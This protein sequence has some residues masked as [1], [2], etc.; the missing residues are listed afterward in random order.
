MLMLIFVLISSVAHTV[1]CREVISLKCFKFR[2][3][4]LE[5]K[6]LSI[7]LG[8]WDNTDNGKI[9]T[10]PQV[11]WGKMLGSTEHTPQWLCK[12]WIWILIGFLIPGQYWSC[13]NLSCLCHTLQHSLFQV[14]DTET[15][16]LPLQVAN[17]NLAEHTLYGSVLQES[18]WTISKDK[19]RLHCD[20]TNNPAKLVSKYMAQVTSNPHNPIS[21]NW[22]LSESITHCNSYFAFL[23]RV[24]IL[25][26]S[27][28]AK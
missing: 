19:M 5:D 24:S 3:V 17:L 8:S 27:S 12:K 14:Y 22:K 2:M 9:Q 11:L 10:K 13:P 1:W 7:I 4:W 28:N 26:M 6:W 18:I 21:G 25:S 23:T 20:S 15:F 16:L